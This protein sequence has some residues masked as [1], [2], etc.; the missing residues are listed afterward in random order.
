MSLIESIPTYGIHYYEVKDKSGI[1]WW[2]GISYKGIS[3]Y[4]HNDRKTPR[5]VFAWKQLENLYFRDRKFSIEVHDPK[6][7]VHTLSNF[8]LYDDAVQESVDDFDE[9]SDAISDPTTLVSVSRRTFGPSS[10]NVH[11]WLTA[12]PQLTKC[13]WT[14]AVAQHQFYLD[15]KQSELCYQ[16]TRSLRDIANDLSRST[17]SLHSSVPS[18]GGGGSGSGGLFDRSG[19]ARS[20]NA[21]SNSR[22]ELVG[23]SVGDDSDSARAAQHDLWLALKARKEHLEIDLKN[24]LEK[25]KE[26]CIKE[27]ELTGELPAETP[28]E[29]GEP[30][31]V[32]RRR[33]GTTF[34]LSPKVTGDGKLSTNLADGMLAKL[35]IEFELQDKI[36]AACHKLTKDTTVAKNIRRKRQQC[37]RK[38]YNKLKEIE[39][40][41][42]EYRLKMGKGAVHVAS[43]Y[44]DPGTFISPV[45]SPAAV[46][47]RA[48]SQCSTNRNRLFSPSP[49]AATVVRHS[50]TTGG[51]LVTPSVHRNLQRHISAPSSP[52]RLTESHTLPSRGGMDRHTYSNYDGHHVLGNG[53]HSIHAGRYHDI[54]TITN[55]DYSD[56]TQASCPVTSQHHYASDTPVD[57]RYKSPAVVTPD[58]F[59]HKLT[60]R[61]ERR[62]DPNLYHVA[63][64]QSS[65]YVSNESL[66]VSAI[67]SASNFTNS[68]QRWPSKHA[69][70]EGA[71]RRQL[72]ETIDRNLS[73][74]CLLQLNSLTLSA[75]DNE[76]TYEALPHSLISP[77][78]YYETP[79]HLRGAANMSYD[80]GGDISPGDYAGMLSRGRNCIEVSKPFEMADVYKYSTRLRRCGPAG[81]TGNS[82][83]SASGA[84][85][86]PNDLRSVS[87]PQLST[88]E[89]G[90]RAM[91][92]LYDVAPMAQQN[93]QMFE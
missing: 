32:I 40:M 35:E 88:R 4:D 18:D 33:V 53:V 10:V 77:P 25:L 5:R 90:R 61:L 71:Y 81:S 26:L 86:L 73:S 80:S 38:A 13:I 66:P 28:L 54:D 89:A 45:N 92:Q 58:G 69:S 30:R 8:N 31:P 19:S 2:L 78:V 49:S 17:S 9:L 84:A 74:G 15:R 79:P 39:R 36:T 24:K 72:S 93:R 1:P 82:S 46:R 41:L 70:L 75:D 55:H 6:R 83:S 21:L 27:A 44:E 91:R 59:L 57:Y 87:S 47:R 20:L 68:T 76:R 12:T 63:T 37:Y 29:P 85:T 23:D 16:P 22:T 51:S 62:P 67:A 34:P 65:A 52:I 50:D 64:N 3:L 43:C 7:V 14:M 11:A 48:N 42:N 56:G 60:S